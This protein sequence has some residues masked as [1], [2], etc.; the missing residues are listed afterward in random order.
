MK[1]LLII[2]GS[3]RKKGCDAAVC[4]EISKMLE[5]HGYESET[6]WAYDLG[7]GGCKA[8]MACKSTQRCVQK[9]CMN[10]ILDKIKNA[11]ALVFATPV[12]FHAETG[13]FKT[14]IDRMYPLMKMN[15]DRTVTSFI[16]KPKKVS[17][18]VTCGAPDGNM[19]FAN[20]V[21]RYIN[22]LKMYGVTDVSGTVIPSAA[23]DTVTGS[24]YFKGYLEELEFQFGN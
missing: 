9:D 7:I 3:P 10:D 5:G 13:P 8:C 16:G 1:K 15:P 20:I 14:F 11:D 23:P 4:D 12:Y 18:V 17:I 24:P 22:V 21:T 19:T 2:N 6:V